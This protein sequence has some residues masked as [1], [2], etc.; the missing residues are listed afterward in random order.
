MKYER[1]V[2][3]LSNTRFSKCLIHIYNVSGYVTLTLQIYCFYFNHQRKRKEIF[4]IFIVLFL[5]VWWY[6][7][8][9]CYRVDNR[10]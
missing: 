7:K 5:V 10:I 4:K 1:S 9:S 3:Y 8:I 2:K 6:K